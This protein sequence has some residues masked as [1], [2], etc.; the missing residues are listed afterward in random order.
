MHIN[1][2]VFLPWQEHTKISQK[3]RSIHIL[4]V[5]KQSLKK[6]KFSQRANQYQQAL[7]PGQRKQLEQNQRYSEQ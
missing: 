2:F 4:K 7:E 1:A 3:A 5:A 6:H